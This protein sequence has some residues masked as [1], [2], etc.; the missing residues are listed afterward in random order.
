MAEVELVKRTLRAIVQANR[1]GVSLS[2]LQLDYKELTGE[3]IPLKEMGHNQLDAL[4]ANTSSVHMERRGSGEVK[5]PEHG[6]H[7]IM[8]DK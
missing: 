4:L 1:G 6:I 7:K 2:R 8:C 3:Q 5:S